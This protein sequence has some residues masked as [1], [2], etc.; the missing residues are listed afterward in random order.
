MTKPSCKKKT[1]VRRVLLGALGAFN[2]SWRS[3]IENVVGALWNGVSAAK[4]L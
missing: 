2:S 1:P 4:I 3:V